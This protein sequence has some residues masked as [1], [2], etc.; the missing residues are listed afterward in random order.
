VTFDRL[1]LLDIEPRP[2]RTE[3][4]LASL[5]TFLATNTGPFIDDTSVCSLQGVYTKG[6]Y[7]TGLQT[8]RISA[9]IAYLGLVVSFK[10]LLFDEDPCERRGVSTTAVKV[11]TDHFTDTASGTE[12]L[13]CEDDRFR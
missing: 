6:A 9:L 5:D 8:G 13:V 2:G 4:L 7:W 10:I 12:R 3:I 11:G 1:L